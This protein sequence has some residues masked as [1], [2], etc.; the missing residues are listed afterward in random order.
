MK[1]DSEKKFR[2]K[3]FQDGADFGYFQ[4]LQQVFDELTKFHAEPA[5]DRKFIDA[6]WDRVKN[7]EE[8]RKNKLYKKYPL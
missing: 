2:L 6:I 7:L 4:A 3:Q 1:S 5:F 8:D